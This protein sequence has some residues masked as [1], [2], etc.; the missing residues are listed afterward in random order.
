[1]T[2]YSM[3]QPVVMV[4]LKA[5]RPDTVKTRLAADLGPERTIDVYRGMVERQLRQIP[6]GW[7][8]EIHYSPADAGAEMQVWLGPCHGYQAQVSGDLGRRLSSGFS[9]AFSR[10]HS[11]VMAIGGDCPELD[12]P[13]FLEAGSR[14]AR[15]D[16]VLGPAEDGGFT[17]IGLRRFAP[18]LFKDIPWS[19]PQVLSLTLAR[20]KL[21]GLTR[22][23]LA[24]KDDIDDLASY[25]RYL[26]R[27]VGESSGETVAVVIPTLNEAERISAALLSARQSFPGA[28]LI[29]VDGGS[30]DGTRDIAAGHEA[31]V[32]TSDRGR[33]SQC[34]AG[35]AAAR[36]A[37]WFLFLHADTVLPPNAHALV[38]AFLAQ[39][40]AQIATFRLR[41]DEPNWFL[42]MCGWFTRIDSVYTRFGDQ[43]I[44]IRR[45]FYEALG[46]FPAWPLFE[47]VA[48][49]QRAR[50][51]TR[52]HSLPGCVTTSARR[53]K[54]RG[55]FTQQWLNARLL[56]RYLGGASPAE[57]AARYCAQP[58][59]PAT[60]IASV[61]SAGRE[62]VQ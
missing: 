25:Q 15:A 12:T 4:F 33:G 18:E 24:P 62:S 31:H 44:L 14:L 22:E 6:A 39:P 59:R 37:N 60:T 41:F 47:D 52:I 57:L 53:F 20:A 27:L 11:I 46:G 17:L 51:V 42:R 48:L 5:P 16:L 43:G 3:S 21:S 7:N 32:I 1:M 10:G 35:V 50:K 30:I 45:E 13:T 61:I 40:R 34:R 9:N 49:L 2:E 54:Q 28:R 58:D 56:L 55:A 26:S 38:N 36:E 29:V 19:T 8:V 23:L